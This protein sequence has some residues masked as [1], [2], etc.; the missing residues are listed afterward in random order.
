LS[1]ALVVL[2]RCGGHRPNHRESKKE[3]GEVNHDVDVSTKGKPL[4]IQEMSAALGRVERRKKFEGT[5]STRK[6]EV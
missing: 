4:Q 3:S 5:S 6:G 2:G 1:N